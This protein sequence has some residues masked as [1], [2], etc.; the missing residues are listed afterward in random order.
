MERMDTCFTIIDSA[1]GPVR[2]TSD[3]TGVTGIYMLD[4]EGEPPSSG[5][6]R[7]DE[8]LRAAREQLLAYFAGDL[9]EFSLPLSPAGTAFQ[10]RV[11]AELTRIPY[12][13]TISYAQLARRIG[14]PSAARAVGAANSKNPIAIVVPCHRVIG[15]AG[16]LTGY[17]GGLDRKRW[18]LEHERAIPKV[19]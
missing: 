17:A 5:A 12:G 2:I 11:W 14:K 6:A 16:A 10:R 7:D 4:H 1:L 13:T 19:R 18:L 8:Q 3:G 15:A 9:E